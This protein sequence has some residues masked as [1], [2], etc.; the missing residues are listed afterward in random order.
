LIPD[1]KAGSF[2]IFGIERTGLEVV[3]VEYALGKRIGRPIEP[4]FGSGFLLAVAAL[5]EV[6]QILV[7]NIVVVL[8]LRHLHECPQQPDEPLLHRE[9][10][11]DRQLVLPRGSGHV[12]RIG[13]CGQGR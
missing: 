8:H 2:I 3:L 6:P 7:V 10:G 5:K 11:V 1:E 4:A 12:K 9:Y 13:S